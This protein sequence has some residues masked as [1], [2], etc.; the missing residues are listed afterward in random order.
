LLAKEPHC[1]THEIIFMLSRIRHCLFS[2]NAPACVPVRAA[3]AAAG[4]IVAIHSL[5]L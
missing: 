2:L 5:T 1:G 3:T 4:R